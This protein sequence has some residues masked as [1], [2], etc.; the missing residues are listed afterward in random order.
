MSCDD[1]L[2]SVGIDVGTTS[3]HMV[4]S[5]LELANVS[6]MN[7]APR[8]SIRGRKILYASPIMFT[9]LD[10]DGTI[11]G[12]AVAKILAAEYVKAGVQPEQITSGALIITGE[13][14][15]ARNAESV[16]SS[17][18]GLAGDFVVA[19][20]G[21]HLESVLAGRGSGAA[22]ASRERA[23]TILNVDIGGGTSNV[24]VFKN[25]DVI[26]TA[27][28]RLGGRCIRL[29]EAGK[30]EHMSE[31][32]YD[33]IDG[34]SRKLKSGDFPEEE[35]LQHL[36]FIIAETIVRFFLPG[37]PPQISQRFVT[38]E[39]LRHDYT[40]DEYWISGGVAQLMK[41][42]SAT[43][44]QFGDIGNYLASGLR[45]SLTERS[46][47]F[48]IPHDPIRAT[49][50]GAG[51]HSMQLSGSTITVSAERLPLRNIQL[52]RPFTG[53]SMAPNTLQKQLKACLERTDLNWKNEPIAIVLG[54]VDDFS[55]LALE[56][57]G[58]S[59]A[60]AFQSLSGSEPLILLS[61]QDIAMA[62]GQILRSLLPGVEIVVLDGISS[63][64]GDFIDIGAPIQNKL[65]LPVV[66]KE[67][68][69][70][71]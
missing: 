71:K 29:D 43:P 65:A 7:Q 21:P 23:I 47:K 26:D 24:A 68:L 12:S 57:L 55:F 40:I 42:P 36:G 54:Q 2:L 51:Q 5:E 19:S 61:A 9:P 16:A 30:V 10:A 15:R 3:T 64:M 52:I 70:A 18:A 8:L 6:T 58:A 14:A 20:A 28:L 4:L 60:A 44:L 27:C 33:F 38:T 17:V 35:L 41:S 45:E 13:T 63:D 59:V 50:I 48:H 39:L 11:D 1:K 34:V 67:L 53:S 66:I 25:G 62:L 32:G 31:S 69:F 46:I 22:Q 56:Q 49:V 37:R